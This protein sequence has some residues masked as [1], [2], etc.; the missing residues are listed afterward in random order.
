M[1]LVRNFARVTGLPRYGALLVISLFIVAGAMLVAPQPALA[2]SP[3]PNTVT[4]ET[5][6]GAS[7]SEKVIQKARS[8][9]PWYVVRASGIVA[10][11]SLVVLML[12]GIGQITGNTYRFLEPLTAWASHRALGIVFGVT[13]VL[14]VGGLLFDHFTSF[15]IWDLLIPWLSDYKPVTLFGIHLGSLYMALG[16]LSFYLTGA[17]VITSLTIINKRSHLWKVIHLASYVI[18][19]MVFV[20]AL[21][22]GTDVSHGWMSAVWFACAAA[23]LGGS[24][25]RLWRAYTT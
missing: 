2:Q 1:Q 23:I 7:V 18:I 22:L 8:S 4:V 21:Y 14:H 13:V 15:T 19:M 9:W 12:S 25:F 11:V 10:A 24:I 5:V 6:Q 17:V 16:V 20:H 3:P